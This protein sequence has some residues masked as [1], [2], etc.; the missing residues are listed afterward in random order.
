MIFLFRALVLLTTGIIPNLFP[1]GMVAG[2][3]LHQGCGDPVQQFA[4]FLTFA[5]IVLGEEV[6]GVLAGYGTHRKII[7]NQK[8]TL[9]IQDGSI[10]NVHLSANGFELGPLSAQIGFVLHQADSSQPYTP[11]SHTLESTVETQCL[12]LWLTLA[13]LA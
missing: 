7:Q 3:L 12:L 13:S 9:T 2:G 6:I 4:P 8:T 1:P 10:P 5:I 11:G